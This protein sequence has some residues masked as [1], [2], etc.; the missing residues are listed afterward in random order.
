MAILPG[1]GSYYFEGNE[2][3]ILFLHGFTGTPQ[4]MRPIAD[5]FARRG[6]TVAGPRLAGHGTTVAD[7]IPTGPQ[8]WLRSANAGLAWV[9]QFARTVFVAGVSLGGTMAFG[10]A[11]EHGD[12][13][14]GVA[15]INAPFL[16]IPALDAIVKDPNAPAT[17]A[18]PWTDPRMLTKDPGAAGI[19]Y[20][21]MPVA[22]LGRGLAY[23]AQVRAHLEQIRIPALLFF[24]ED[25]AI[26]DPANGPYVLEHLG[27]PSKRLVKLTNSNHEATLDFDK[28]RIAIELEAFI[29][30]HTGA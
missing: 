12:A 17:V 24:S 1:A 25:D 14:T 23:A 16:D 20:F 3:G 27:S 5:Y 28:E 11:V 15:C 2:I 4:N 26:V 7:M 13:L 21:E 30:E 22:A 10:M 19:V 8:D 18:A 6:Y 29:R 9:R